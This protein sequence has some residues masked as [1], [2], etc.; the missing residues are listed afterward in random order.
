MIV[1]LEY[2]TALNLQLSGIGQASFSF[3]TKGF[4]E[5][6]GPPAIHPMIYM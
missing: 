4:P 6:L 2:V 3:S 5:T 1:L